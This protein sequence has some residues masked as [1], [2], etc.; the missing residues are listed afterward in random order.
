MSDDLELAARI[1]AVIEA[2]LYALPQAEK[3]ARLTPVLDALT[4]HHRAACPAYRR[5]T[6]VL[7]PGARPAAALAEVPWLPVGLWKSHRLVSVPTIR[8]RRRSPRAAPPARCRAASTSTATPRAARAAG[9][10]GS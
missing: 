9:W 1:D 7:G 8:S 6:D 4:R 10:R 5:L 2:P 3:A